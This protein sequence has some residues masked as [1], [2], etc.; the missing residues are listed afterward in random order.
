MIRRPPRATRTD[1]LFPYTTL[2]RSN[3]A[4]G[5]WF[6]FLEGVRY[7]Q[8][9][10]RRRRAGAADDRRDAPRDRSR[11]RSRNQIGSAHVRTPVTNAHLVCRLLLEKKNY[12]TLNY[13][14]D[15]LQIISDVRTLLN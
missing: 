4:L 12:N 7:A 3:Q 8:R 6:E 15:L 5:R 10:S 1:T 11:N 14:Y 13:L 2:F 9:L